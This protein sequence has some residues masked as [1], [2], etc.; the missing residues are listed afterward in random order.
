MTRFVVDKM[1]E[2]WRECPAAIRDCE[3]GVICGI[4]HRGC[5]LRY[6]VPCVVLVDFEML[7]K[8]KRDAAELERIREIS[9]GRR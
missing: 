9:E 4:N 1:P 2:N 5:A 8:E 6:G 7:E 3:G